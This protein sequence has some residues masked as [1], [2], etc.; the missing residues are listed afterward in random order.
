MYPFEKGDQLER[1][2][3]AIEQAILAQSPGLKQNAFRIESKKLLVSDG[4]KHE[5]DLW[6]QVD[7]GPGYDSIFIFECKNWEEKVSKNEII[8]FSEKIKATNAQRGFF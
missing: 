4:V 6:V 1:A 5:I 8:I 7:I 3:R 2:V